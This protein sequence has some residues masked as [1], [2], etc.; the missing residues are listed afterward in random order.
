MA[1]EQLRRVS[2]ETVEAARRGSDEAWRELF[3]AHYPKLIRFFRVRVPTD[4]IADDLAA[5]A[6]A[7]AFRSIGRFRWRRRPFE[8]WVFGIARNRLKMHYRS[9][10]T[11]EPLSD[12][13][14]AFRD[15]FLDIDLRDAL[16]R[17]PDDYREAI[18][19]RYVVGLS[20]EEAAAAMDRS[21]NA[22]RQ[23]LF[24]ATRQFKREFGP[25]A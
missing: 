8:A 25:D 22:F 4:Q 12:R 1:Q 24:R 14:S 6:F 7:E 16:D 10:R 20:G 13:M 9:L 17:L 2:M 5:D 18:V 21:H 15:E 3:D 19:Y 11:A 23:L